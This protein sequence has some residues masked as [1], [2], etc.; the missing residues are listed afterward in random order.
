MYFGV[1]LSDVDLRKVSLR[2]AGVYIER[3]PPESATMTAIR[4][5]T[6]E[7]PSRRKRDKAADA[8]AS[9][10]MPWSSDQ[11]LIAQL[12]DEIR[13]LT[14]TVRSIMADSPIPP[15]EPV[16]RPG[17]NVPRRREKTKMTVA[18]ARE[19]D[20]RLRPGSGHTFMDG[21]DGSA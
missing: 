10:K 7:A 12:I 17:V 15:P 8:E 6:P 1:E 20:P 16:Y 11:M 9:V 13:I 19:L 2:K 18:Q 14:H 5:D 21:R 4:L 3:L